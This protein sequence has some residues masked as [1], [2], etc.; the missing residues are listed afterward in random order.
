MLTKPN[1]NLLPD[2]VEKSPDSVVKQNPFLWKTYIF[3]ND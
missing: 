1:G 3:E 2:T